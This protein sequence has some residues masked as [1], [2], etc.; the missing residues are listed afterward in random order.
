[1]GMEFGTNVINI[2]LSTNW[3]TVLGKDL[4][5]TD[6]TKDVSPFYVYKFV[7]HADST[8]EYVAE[9]SNRGL[10]DRDS[11]ICGS[12][13]VTLVI[14]VRSSQAWPCKEAGESD[15]RYK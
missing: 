11:G 12:L 10:C 14:A 6:T 13:L 2:D 4:S 9:C 1:M 15:N 5:S 8:Y 3:G 7:P